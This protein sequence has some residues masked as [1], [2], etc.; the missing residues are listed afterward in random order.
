MLRLLSRAAL[1]GCFP[2]ASC[3]TRRCRGTMLL[4]GRCFVFHRADVVTLRVLEANQDSHRRNAGFRHRDA[5]A[6]ALHRGDDGV[7]VVHRD[8]GLEAVQSGPSTR[9]LTLVHEALDAR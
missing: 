2:T 5:S 3:E 9:L 7:E 1:S 4:S 8:R 6:V